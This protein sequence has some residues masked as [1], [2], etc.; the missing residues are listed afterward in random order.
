M[1][2]LLLYT[3]VG[4]SEAY[5]NLLTYFCE[6]LCFTN[7][8]VKNLLVM[9]DISFHTKVR[10]IL[11]RFAFLN[12]HIM[13][14]P[15]AF[16]GVEASM[17]KTKIF[18]WPH[19]MEYN[20]CLFVDADCLFLQDLEFIFKKPIQ[21]N[22]LYVYA[23]RDTPQENIT[24]WFC[25]PRIDDN[26]LV[27]YTETEFRW[28]ID[29]NKRPFN[30][31]LFLFK[32]SPLMKSH[33]ENLN[34]FIKNWKGLYFYEQSFMNTYFHL[35]DLSDFSHFGKHNIVMTQ[36]YSN[37]PICDNHKIVHFNGVG[38]SNGDAKQVEMSAYL[39]DTLL[40]RIHSFISFDN[41]LQMIQA[42]IPEHATIAEIGV[43]KGQFALELLKKNP[44]HLYLIDC[45]TKGPMVSG[46]QDGNNVEQVPD[47]EQLYNNLK[48][49][50]K[51]YPN[52]SLHRQFST[53]FLPL[54]KDNTLDVVYIDGD[55]SYEGVK[56][57][58][59]FSYS[60]IKKYGWIMGHDYEMN[61]AKTKH[62]YNFGTKQAVDEFCAK[63][64][65]KI[66]AKGLD[67]CVSYAIW[68]VPN[69]IVSG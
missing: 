11:E 4:K 44:K 5:L 54:L 3:T 13:D 65:L 49:R 69:L 43:F 38:A 39:N 56:K 7:T 61:Y 15:D 25:L 68:K 2:K 67:G 62:T 33:F 16:S 21:D 22:K 42:L 19:I 36:R 24:N 64:N 48:T 1:D 28:I 29:N 6:S 45:W 51:F 9:C 52:V 18:E 66:Y 53:D 8:G 20:T 12:W 60:K 46:D 63:H 26:K 57:D 58:L 50:L 34:N 47:C 30:A 55:H 14:M 27:Y 59:E 32:I 40:K 35:T 31:G 23:E 41:R 37:Q 10:T 17:Q